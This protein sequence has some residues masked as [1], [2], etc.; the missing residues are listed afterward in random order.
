VND[1]EGNL[2]PIRKNL[3]LKNGLPVSLVRLRPGMFEKLRIAYQNYLKLYDAEREMNWEHP[4]QYMVTFRFEKMVL[5]VLVCEAVIRSV[6][7]AL[8]SKH[9]E[10]A[11]NFGMGAF[12]NKRLV[13]STVPEYDEWGNILMVWADSATASNPIVRV[14]KQAI[15]HNVSPNLASLIYRKGGS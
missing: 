7:Q 8:N 2:L 13:Y 11:L 12:L 6:L 10:N 15:A 4:R 9:P 5:H 14:M 3:T 1:G